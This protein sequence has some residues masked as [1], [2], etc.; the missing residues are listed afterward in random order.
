MHRRIANHE[1]AV[2]SQ[3]TIVRPEIKTLADLRQRLGRI[4]LDRIWFHPAPGTATE[5]DVIEAEERENR[6]CELVD[7]TLVEKAVGCEEARLAIELT[8]L[9]KCYLDE[10]ELGIC[11]GADGMM[12]IAPG[13]ARIPDR[14]E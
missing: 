4:P 8:L 6:L 7:G 2:M 14:L 1:K 5:N 12:R 13:L 10:N 11:V 9:I 3:A